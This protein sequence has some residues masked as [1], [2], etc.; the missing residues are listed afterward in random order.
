MIEIKGVSKKFV[1]G[2]GNQVVALSDAN[3]TIKD[4]EFVTLIGPSGCGKTT[5]LKMVDGLIPWTEGQ[6]AIDGKPVNGP[7]PDRAMVFQNFALLPWADILTNV[8]FGLEAR[9]ISKN[10]RLSAAREQ[11]ARVGLK[12]FENAYPRELS[13]GM[14]QRAALA[15]ALVLRPRILLM[16]EPF[17]ALDAQTRHLLQ[18]DLLELWQQERQTVL[19]VTH[20]MEE[21]VFLSDRV[22]I[23]FPRP[24]RVAEILEV[25]IPRPRDSHGLRR[26]PKFVDMTSYIWDRLRDLVRQSEAG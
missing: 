8:A 19:F 5:L 11:I 26:D 18:E 23:M 22:V 17:A 6:I 9:G 10:E 1:T 20:S 13:G 24:G 25:P 7:G 2:K 3:L 12:G 15:R 21:A 16:D 14:Q 4:G